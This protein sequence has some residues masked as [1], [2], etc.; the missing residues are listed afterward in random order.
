MAITK[1]LKNYL[2]LGL[3]LSIP[4]GILAFKLIPEYQNSKRGLHP[5]QENYEAYYDLKPGEFIEVDMS[6][7]RGQTLLK[8]ESTGSARLNYEWSQPHYNPPWATVL[9]GVSKPRVNSGLRKTALSAFSLVGCHEARD[10]SA[11]YRCSA[12]ADIMVLQ[13]K[14]LASHKIKKIT[15]TGTT[16]G[17]LSFPIRPMGTDS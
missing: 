8:I 16:S 1:K 15:I 7:S 9:Y 4:I 13:T 17:D 2:W 10:L 5:R 6:L 12:S 14:L 3:Y 11:W